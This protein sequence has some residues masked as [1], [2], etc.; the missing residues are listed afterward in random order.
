MPG[1]KIFISFDYENDKEFKNLL[2]AWSKNQNFDINFQDFSSNEI[3]SWDIG[4]IKQVLSTKINQANYTLVIVGKEANKQHKDHQKIGYKNW[5]NYEIAKS[6]EHKNQLIAVKLEKSY[7]SPDELY[8]A[9]A[10]WAL[11]FTKDAV[12]KAIDEA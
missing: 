1:K 6:K 5:L 3:N 9:G 4:T 11:S 12:I 2:V 7:E 8:N 10:T